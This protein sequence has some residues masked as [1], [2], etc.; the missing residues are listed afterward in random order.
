MCTTSPPSYVPFAR[1]PQVFWLSRSRY[2]GGP[3]TMHFTHSVRAYP[4]NRRRMTHLSRQLSV[5]RYAPSHLDRLPDIARDPSPLKPVHQCHEFDT[6]PHL[7][8]PLPY[9]PLPHFIA[10]E[11][12]PADL[13][14]FH[15]ESPFCPL[16]PT[17][18]F[19]SYHW[20]FR[21]DSKVPLQD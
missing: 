5:V 6:N 7:S 20:G 1:N 21:N 10:G 17:L 3:T 9:Q 18:P 8:T 19:H 4:V 13:G 11:K 16:S 14:S 12:N 15:N 2:N